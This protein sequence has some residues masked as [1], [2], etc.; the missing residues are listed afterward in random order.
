MLY[1]K[2]APTGEVIFTVPV[3]TL[4]VGC[5]MLTTAVAG[6]ACTVKERVAVA[7]AHPP[8]PATVYVIVTVPAATPVAIPVVGLILAIAVLE[9]LQV[10]PL[11]V[12]VRVVVK[13][14]HKELLPDSV[15]AL[16]AAVMVTVLLPTAFAHPPVPVT[17]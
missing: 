10:P 11:A 16:G 9:L 8:L 14:T 2:P 7:L 4:Q 5:V 12:E 1:V 17:V 3:A 6:S 13:P 15:P